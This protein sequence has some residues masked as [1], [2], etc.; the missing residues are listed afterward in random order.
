M[1]TRDRQAQELLAKVHFDGV[2]GGSASHSTESNALS[3]VEARLVALGN[4]LRARDPDGSSSRAELLARFASAVNQF[5]TPPS[6][7]AAASVRPPSASAR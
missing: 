2:A 4:A 7:P 3:D 1:P 5:P 6:G